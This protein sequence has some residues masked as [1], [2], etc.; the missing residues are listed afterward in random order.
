MALIATLR[1]VVAA[2]YWS[3]SCWLVNRRWPSLWRVHWEEFS[4]RTFNKVVMLAQ[5]LFTSVGHGTF[6]TSC[7]HWAK[8]WAAS[9]AVVAGTPAAFNLTVSCADR[10][11]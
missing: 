5:A 11:S 6:P 3:R 7:A 4:E 10:S 8:V 1:S 2:L 9:C